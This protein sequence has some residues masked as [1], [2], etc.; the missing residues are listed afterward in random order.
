M[1]FLILGNCEMFFFRLIKLHFFGFSIDSRVSC[2][3][4][5][6]GSISWI[7]D[8]SSCDFRASFQMCLKYETF[9]PIFLYI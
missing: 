3:R 2:A 5:R 8:L 4:T 6:I 9:G 7:N 1:N